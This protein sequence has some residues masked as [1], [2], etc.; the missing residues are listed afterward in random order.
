[1]PAISMA[2]SPTYSRALAH[3]PRHLVTVGRRRRRHVA[4]MGK[5]E[6][7][8]RQPVEIRHLVVGPVEMVGVDHQARVVAP[9][10]VCRTSTASAS[11]L[12]PA[13]WNVFK[14]DGQ[15]ERLGQVA[16]LA[17]LLDRVLAIV[18]PD[19]AQHRP[20]VQ[21]GRH[22]HGRQVACRVQVVVDAHQLNVVHLE[23]RWRPGPAWSGAA[24]QDS[25]RGHSWARRAGPTG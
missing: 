18:G 23:P 12:T 6:P 25:R 2:P 5:M 15:P 10:T 11:V 19:A 3:D 14:I 16:D 20:C 8:G 9:F 17:E 1:M 24:F 7:L 22:L 4:N 21:F 13:I